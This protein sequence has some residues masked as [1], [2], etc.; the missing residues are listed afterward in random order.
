MVKLWLVG[1]VLASSAC[2]SNTTYQCSDDSQCD[3]G[4]GGR[5]EV[6][7]YCTSRDPAC[8]TLRSH[9]EL[10]GSLTN[11]C[12][13]DRR[14]PAN[15]CAGGQA[16]AAREG[17]YAK[18]CERVPACCDI[19][20]TDTCAQLAQEEEDC[21]LVCDTRIALTATRG[22]NI[23]RWD[24]LWTGTTWVSKQETNLGGPFGWIAPAPGSPTP[25]LVGTTPTTLEIG[26]TIIPV[27]AGRDYQSI[28]SI[29]FDRDNRDTVAAVYD[30][31]GGAA[32]EIYKLDE[33]GAVSSVRELSL[34]GNIDGTAL[35]WGDLDRDGFPD[36]VSKTGGAAYSYLV[37]IEDADFARKLTAQVQSNT[38]GGATPGAP[39]TRSV[40]WLD[41]DGDALLDLVVF[42]SSVRFHTNADGLRDIAERD[43]DCIPP[44]TQK[45][46]SDD[47]EPNLE[48]SSFAGAGFPTADE[49][50]VIIAAFPARKLYRARQQGDA[51]I[52]APLSFPGDGC[53]CTANCTMCPGANCSCTYDCSSCVTI[54]GVVARDLDGDH[55]LDL[56]AIDARLRIHT[57]L[58]PTFTWS[59][60]TQIQTSFANT[61]VSLALSVTGAPR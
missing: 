22:A 6:T 47:P 21:A 58:A 55:R 30:T 48:A 37:N 52:V 43:L 40:D 44:S 16:P 57:A 51:V 56:V 15:P 34:A 49:P 61:F 13:D 31:S 24:L 42:G 1:V 23:E 28:T 50:S 45:A 18:V 27:P 38:S 3:L 54:L 60:P 20:W 11:T 17:C 39:Q 32:V 10:A 53:T 25:R 35:A 5:C 41:L 12:Y 36:A 33:R 9:E 2:F 26:T 29:G 19:A 14:V 4:T 46:C 59:A 7:H 8:D